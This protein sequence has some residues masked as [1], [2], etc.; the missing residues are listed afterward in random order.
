MVWTRPA[1]TGAPPSPRHGHAA[2]ALGGE[3]FL[4]GG[5]ASAGYSHELHVLKL[6]EDLLPAGVPPPSPPPPPDF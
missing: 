2:V 1:L 6:T 5:M 3:I 4:F